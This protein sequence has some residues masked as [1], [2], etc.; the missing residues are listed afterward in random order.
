MSVDIV[1][2]ASCNFKK[3]YHETL[4]SILSNLSFFGLL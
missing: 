1:I 2:I 3:A 4:I